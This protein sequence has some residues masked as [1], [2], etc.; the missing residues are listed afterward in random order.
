MTSIFTNTGATSALKILRSL[1]SDSNKVQTQLSSGLR[2]TS[3]ADNAAYWSIATTMRSDNRSISAIVDALS[4]GSAKVD[5]ASVAMS[6]VIEVISEFK[7]KLVAS[8]E[9]GVDRTKIQSELE[10]L[11]GQVVSIATSASFNGENWL[12]TDIVDMDDALQTTQKLVSSFVRSSEGSVAIN[13]AAVNL[14]EIALFNTS[15][16]G[17]LEA[18]PGVPSMNFGGLE[19]YPQDSAYRYFSFAYPG[20]VTFAPGDSV[21]FDITLDANG[22]F[23]GQTYTVH[24][25][26]ALVNSVRGG[27][28]G[29][30]GGPGD[31]Q[32]ILYYAFANAGVP[33]FVSSGGTVGS[34][35]GR[36]N[37]GSRGVAGQPVT[38]VQ[39]SNFVSSLPG[40]VVMGLENPSTGSFGD[41]YASGFMEFGEPFMVDVADTISFDFDIAH[42]G[43]QP[44]TIT[45]SDVDAA[46]GRGN[47]I[48]GDAADM[49]KLLNYKL[50]GAGL[51]ATGNTN[52]VSLA[53]DTVM[54]PAIESHSYYKFTNVNGTVQST[55]F[56]FLEIDISGGGGVDRYL[57]GLD[58]MLEAVISG[59]S[60]LGAMQ[61]R[62][63]L[64]TDFTNELQSTIDRGIG[65][66]VDADMQEVSARL[67]AIQTQKELSLQALNIANADP[68]N[69]M[70]LFQ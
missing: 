23:I 34:D 36:V 3:A 35:V 56:D 43:P 26:Y 39:L 33:A 24:V 29:A 17:L 7:A 42:S 53:I 62:I 48:V 6:S 21:S 44:Y 69:I 11:K 58:K 51:I 25:D 54:H 1:E 32:T 47:G 4:L 40:G 20:S 68:Q 5:T 65:N 37:I 27:S 30:T 10:Q 9:A 52:T 31:W 41:A 50:A 46:L 61:N 60:T 49:A 63:R 67:K 15:G 59:A 28:S 12:N 8:K 55:N 14:A 45:R 70:R 64:Q 57:R 22:A 66:L 2:V 38:N 16:S 18:K 19:T 13:T